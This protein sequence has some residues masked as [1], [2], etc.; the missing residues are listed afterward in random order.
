MENPFIKECK[1]LI[2]ALPRG[3]MKKEYPHWNKAQVINYWWSGDIMEQPEEIGVSL[4]ENPY[5]PPSIVL[6]GYNPNLDNILDQVQPQVLP[7]QPKVPAPV[8]PVERV[9]PNPFGALRHRHEVQVN[10]Q[11]LP[12][13]TAH[14]AGPT[15]GPSGVPPATSGA[16]TS[17]VPTNPARSPADFRNYN[18]ANVR[19]EMR[20]AAFVD[21]SQMRNLNPDEQEH[22]RRSF[23]LGSRVRDLQ[24]EE[25]RPTRTNP[26][27]LRTFFVKPKTKK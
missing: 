23:Y 20:A 5:V 18:L 14:Q 7:A 21:A 22:F 13:Q 17:G 10:P 19:P 4:Q 26:S 15:A 24:T 9:G 1:K 25:G 11:T 2:K 16:S 27:G 12:A 6:R 3:L 8:L